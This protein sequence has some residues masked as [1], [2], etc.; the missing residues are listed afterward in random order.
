MC[1]RE[2]QYILN[3]Y[4]QNKERC[5]SMLDDVFFIQGGIKAVVYTDFFQAFILFGGLLAILIVVS[6]YKLTYERL[7]NVLDRPTIYLRML[8]YEAN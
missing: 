7:L 1:Q 4:Q 5:L 6:S 2:Q 3:I 8:Y